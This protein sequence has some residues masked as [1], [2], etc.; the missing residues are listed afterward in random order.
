MARDIAQVA[1]ILS[2]LVHLTAGFNPWHLIKPATVVQPYNLI[3]TKVE[4]GESK[5][6]GH[7]QFG[8]S[9]GYIRPYLNQSI[10]IS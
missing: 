6:Q 2:Y 10:G 8:V 3:S 4:P 7:L 9:I 1:R 5:A